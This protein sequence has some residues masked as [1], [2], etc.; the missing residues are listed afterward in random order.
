MTSDIDS[1]IVLC[2][3]CNSTKPHKQREPL[4]IYLIPDLPWLFVSAEI[5]NWNVLRYLIPVD[6]YSGLLATDT[7]RDLS[8]ITVI[9]RIKLRHC[10]VVHGVYY[11]VFSASGPQFASR[12][13]QSLANEW[14]FEDA[15]S[16]PYH[17][18]SNSLAEN[19]VKQA[20]NLLCKCKKEGSDPFLGLLN[21]FNVPRDQTLG[22]PPNSCGKA[23]P[24]S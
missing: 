4:V 13:F 1:A 6:S 15:T 9:K 19:D 18:Q 10:F 20:K 17:P 11:K 12:K 7:R 21:L 23:A 2:K 22:S 3:L 24:H 8:S 14:S 16:I 5:L